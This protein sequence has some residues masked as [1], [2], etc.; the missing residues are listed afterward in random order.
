MYKNEE[1]KIWANCES[2]AKILGFKNSKI[3]VIFENANGEAKIAIYDTHSQGPE[4]DGSEFRCSCGD[5][6][7]EALTSYYGF[8]LQKVREKV[9][10]LIEQRED[11]NQ[12]IDSLSQ[13]IDYLSNIEGFRSK[14]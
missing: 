3:K 12:K 8:L 11:L 1:Q 2:L 7:L 13:E 14:N 6:L 9:G 5:T 10:N 4:A